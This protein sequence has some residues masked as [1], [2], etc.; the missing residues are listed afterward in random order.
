[1]E[2]AAASRPSP[3][4][5]G[6]PMPPGKP[7]DAPAKRNQMPVPAAVRMASAAASVSNA[8]NGPTMHSTSVL[9]AP[10]DDGAANDL[11]RGTRRWRSFEPSD[12][13]L[14]AQFVRQ[15]QRIAQRRGDIGLAA[16]RGN[17]FIEVRRVVG[18]HLVDRTG[19]DTAQSRTQR[20]QELRTCAH[21]RPPTISFT[22]RVKE[23][24]ALRS[25]TSSARPAR[26]M[27]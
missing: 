13:Q 16:I 12:A 2:T 26:V 15:H 23:C 1:M 25:R 10:I 22:A 18:D 20:G 3:Q 21:L 19:G 14:Q 5:T 7:S 27:R 9:R 4:S 6:V 8:S 17:A 11:R 24:Q